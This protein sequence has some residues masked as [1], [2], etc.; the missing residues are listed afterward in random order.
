MPRRPIRESVDARTGER[1]SPMTRHDSR[2]PTRDGVTGQTPRAGRKLWIACLAVLALGACRGSDPAPAD[3]FDGPR[4]FRD[5]VDLVALGPRPAGSPGAARARRLIRERLRQAGWPVEEHRF[6]VTAPHG[7]TLE[8]VNLIARH[9][10][11]GRGARLL[12]VTHYDT[13]RLSGERFVGANDGASGVALLLELARQLAAA[14]LWHTLELVFFDG[15]EAVLGDITAEDGLYGSR[16]LAERMLRE[17]SLQTVRALLL[18]D[19]VA[20]RELGLTPDLGASPEL[21]ELVRE[22]AHG[23]GLGAL[24]EGGAPL[25]LVDD[26]SPFVERGVKRVY[27]FIDFQFGGPRAPG[28][29]WHTPEDDLDAV[30]SSS[31]NSVGRLV[32][33]TVRRID[34]RDAERAAR[35]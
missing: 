33:E 15:E 34:R 35:R 21:R 27:S 31:L 14:P 9:S 12:V 23:L 11:S 30:S 24:L 22:A 20:D 3:G 19:M 4:A 17:G 32:V 6:R 29:L 26:H 18:V 13:K 2:R 7:R 16:A 8:L 28:R 5:L 1:R 25:R 10:G